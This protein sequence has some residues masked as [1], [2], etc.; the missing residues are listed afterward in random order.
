MNRQPRI[1]V[2]DR[3]NWA[4]SISVVAEVKVPTED[5]CPDEDARVGL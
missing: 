4:V 3:E 1:D 5:E 2:P